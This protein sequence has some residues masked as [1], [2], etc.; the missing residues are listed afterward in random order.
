[1][2]LCGIIAEYNPL[3][4]GHERHI[5]LAKEKSGCDLIAAVMSGSF[6]QR[7][8][9]A[10]FDKWT[11]TRWALRA[12]ADVVFELPA[13]YVLQA[14]SG[15]AMGGVR[16]LYATGMLSAL[17]FGCE[18]GG[19]EE[20]KALCACCEDERYHG[21]IKENL[22]KGMSYAAAEQAALFALRPDAAGLALS[23]NF[24]LGLSYARAVN[25]YA[26]SV[27]LVPVMREGAAH[28]DDSFFGRFSSASAF[29]AALRSKDREKALSDLPAYAAEDAKSTPCVALEDLGQAVLYALRSKSAAKLAAFAGVDEGLENVLVRAGGAADLDGALAVLKSKRYTLARLRRLLCAALVGFTKETL[30]TANEGPRYLRILGV[31]KES[32]GILGELSKDAGL[33]VIV[34]KSDADALSQKARALYDLDVAASNIAALAWGCEAWRDYTEPLIVL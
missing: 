17:S 5:A 34:K 11:R 2:S 20:L 24:M 6:V 9:P 10:S 30:K 15:F 33:P 31:R 26:P 3:H 27:R 7:G 18:S 32:Q 14:A 1:M 21:I 29:R 16:T 19:V 22:N 4:S 25:E 8:A 12:G 23:P 28:T 13:A